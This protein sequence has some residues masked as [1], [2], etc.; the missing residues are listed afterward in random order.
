M[1]RQINRPQIKE[2]ENPPE[3]ESEQGI[4]NLFEKIMTENFPNLVKEKGTLVQ[5]AQRVPNKRDAKSHN[6]THY[7]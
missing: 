1:K 5:E 4:K 2:Q 3:E 7:N 6:K